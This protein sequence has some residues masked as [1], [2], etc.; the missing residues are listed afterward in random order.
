VDVWFGGARSFVAVLDFGRR[1]I[2]RI[3]LDPGRRF[4]DRDLTDNSWPR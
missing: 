3:S 2:E 1:K 4:P